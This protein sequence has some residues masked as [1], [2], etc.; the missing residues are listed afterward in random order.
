[1]EVSLT[2]SLIRDEAGEVVGTSEVARDVTEQKRTAELMRQTQKLE[3]LGVLAGGIAHD[4]NNLL[5]GVLGNSSLA[6][7]LLEP[8]SPVRSLL[9]GVMAAGENAAGLTQQMLAYSGKAHFVLTKLNLSARVRETIPLI[10]A[11]VSRSV[12]LRLDLEDDLPPIDADASQVQQIVM[13]PGDQR[14]RSHPGKPT[15]PGA[16]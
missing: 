14:R 5:V 7:D 15:R 3:S 16:H 8:D 4:F 1:V 13:N 10:Q 6:L 9:E 12:E 2:I 11:A